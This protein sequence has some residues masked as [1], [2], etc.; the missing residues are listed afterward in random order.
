[1]TALLALRSMGR[2]GDAID[3][4]FASLTTWKG[5]SDPIQSTEA[6]LLRVLVERQLG[7]DTEFR[8]QLAALFSRQQPDG[9][10][11]WLAG[12]PSD[13]FATGQVLYA[14]A[15]I[16]DADDSPIRGAWMFL[17]DSQQPDGSWIVPSTKAG[18]D[19]SQPASIQWG[20]G[21]GTIGLLSTLPPTP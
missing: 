16:G 6:L 20:T 8:A 18:V 1:M 3:R 7:L 9:G 13:A 17:R 19:G 4:G 14:L 12:E 5:S 21:W 11:S 15:A 10:W 2:S